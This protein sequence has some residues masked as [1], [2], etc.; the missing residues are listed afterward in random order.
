MTLALAVVGP[1]SVWTVV[2]RRLT[3]RGRVVREDARKMMFLETSDDVAI[4]AYAGVGATARGTEPADWMSAV[5]R[6]RK[7]SIEQSLAT[8]A[9]ALK[10]EMPPHLAGL[11]TPRGPSHSV[12]VAAFVNDEQRIYTIHL[13]LSADRRQMV[14]RNTRWVVSTEHVPQRTPRFALAGSGAAILAGDRL[15]RRPLLRLVKAFDR[16]LVAAQTVADA[17]AALN[18]RVSQSLADRTVG[19]RCIVAWRNRRTG[20]HRGGGGHQTYTG[21]TRDSNTPS[22]PSIGNGLDIHALVQVFMPH[23][24]KQLDAIRDGT[25]AP[26]LDTEALNAGLAQLPEGPDENLR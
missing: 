18:L 3:D 16:R 6:G 11:R 13:A 17:L 8:L 1:E 19:P 25:S 22:L 9:E 2:D 10:R 24:M 15:W 23:T 26:E 7:L 20:V 4:L 21:L 5:L 12:V 14:F